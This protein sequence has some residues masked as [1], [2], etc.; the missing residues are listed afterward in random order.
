[1]YMDVLEVRMTYVVRHEPCGGL[2]LRVVDP[3]HEDGPPGGEQRVEEVV[4]VLLA[5]QPLAGEQF[6]VALDQLAPAP[7]LLAHPVRAHA[8]HELWGC[9]GSSRRE[10]TGRGR[11]RNGTCLGT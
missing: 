8:V 4:A 6:V 10:A 9:K 3:S 2:Q 11:T 5:D 1:M 7:V